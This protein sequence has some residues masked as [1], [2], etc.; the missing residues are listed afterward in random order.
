VDTTKTLWALRAGGRSRRSFAAA[1]TTG[2]S[3]WQTPW[4]F[5][6]IPDE[7]AKRIINPHLKMIMVWPI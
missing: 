5:A 3:G 1:V 7:V 4:D 2:R 6:Y